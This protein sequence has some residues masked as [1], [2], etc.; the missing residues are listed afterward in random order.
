MAKI[1][2]KVLYYHASTVPG[3]RKEKDKKKELQVLFPD[4]W[5]DG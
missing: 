3:L 4:G 2:G 1:Q 5:M